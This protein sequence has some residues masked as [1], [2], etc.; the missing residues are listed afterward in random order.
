MAANCADGLSAV[1]YQLL[2]CFLE[3]AVHHIGLSGGFTSD[4]LG[5][6]PRAG[7]DIFTR[8]TNHASEDHCRR[9]GR[10][11]RRRDI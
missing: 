2:A 7:V 4:D 3:R 11:W 9:N 10:H 8:R 5:I 1:L 6:W